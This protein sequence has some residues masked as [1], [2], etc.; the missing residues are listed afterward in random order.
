MGL[1]LIL[2]VGSLYCLPVCTKALNE[3]DPFVPTVK[4]TKQGVSLPII[5]ISILYSAYN[6][7]C[8]EGQLEKVEQKDQ[9]SYRYT[10]HRK[11]SE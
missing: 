5:H 1:G 11:T 3:V 10:D 2:T 8:S 4:Y 9:I 6:L 7:I